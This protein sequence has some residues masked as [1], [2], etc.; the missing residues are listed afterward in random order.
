M[1]IILILIV[2]LFSS[3]SNFKAPEPEPKKPSLF[4]NLKFDTDKKGLVRDATDPFGNE[5]I[6]DFPIN[7]LLWQASIDI[8]SVLSLDTVDPKS[9]VISS[10]WTTL[11]ENKNIRYKINLYFV[12]PDLNA[13]SINVSVIRQKREN[14]QWVSD[15]Q[16]KELSNKIEDL[17]LTRA[18]EIR[19]LKE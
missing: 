3:C 4:G 2:M 15:G 14:N 16:S 5:N 6:E 19:Q 18:K 12:S 7:S 9:G 11:D 8:M 13:M 10:H 1:R 17:V